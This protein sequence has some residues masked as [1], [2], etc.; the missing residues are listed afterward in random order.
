MADLVIVGTGPQALTLS[1]LL[2]QK[3]PRLP[4]IAWLMTAAAS[5]PSSRCRAVGMA[6]LIRALI[7]TLSGD[8]PGE[9]W[10]N[11][12]PGG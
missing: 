6:A 5:S 9:S 4:A 8:R 1:C 11:R 2:L 12:A 3:R 10:W 7:D